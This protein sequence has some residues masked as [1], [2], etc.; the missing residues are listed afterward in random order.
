MLGH[1]LVN[2]REKVDSCRWGEDVVGEGVTVGAGSAENT[3][4]LVTEEFEHAFAL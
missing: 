3:S 1:N 2:V 4:E